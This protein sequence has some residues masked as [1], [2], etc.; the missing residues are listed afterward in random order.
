MRKIVTGLF[1]SL[2]GVV[3]SPFNWATPYFNDEMFEVIAAGIAQAD[4]IPAGSTHVPRVRRNVAEPGQLGADGRLPEQHAQVRGI[5][6]PGRAR[7]GPIP[8][9]AR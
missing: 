3:E 4:A 8:P 5:Q 2:D 9:R 7:M 1:M 6:H